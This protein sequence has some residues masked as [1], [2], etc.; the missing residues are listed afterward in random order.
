[1]RASTLACLIC[2]MTL[3]CSDSGGDG[4]TDSDTDTTDADTDSD[5][6]TDTDVDPCTPLDLGHGFTIDGESPGSGLNFG[7][8]CSVGSA[9]FDAGLYQLLLNCDD[10]SGAFSLGIELQDLDTQPTG[11]NP[12]AMLDVFV[13]REAAV[14]IE[15]DPEQ[16]FEVQSGGQLL[17]AGH[18]RAHGL[19]KVGSIDVE[20]MTMCDVVEGEPLPAGYIHAATADGE[21]DIALGEAG[22]VSEGG[23]SWSV[24]AREAIPS[25]CVGYES[26]VIIARQ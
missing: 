17:L 18:V 22:T 26:S 5:T 14:D 11:I 21:V 9:T 24:Y 23:V 25:C 6:G 3:A 19:R 20:A 13:L 15:T 4:E 10:G 12:G 1:M 16:W 7:G 2:A 8:Q